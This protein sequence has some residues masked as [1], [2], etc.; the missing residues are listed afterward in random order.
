M[1]NKIVA[2]DGTV[3]L[4]YPCLSVIAAQTL[5]YTFC[6][7]KKDN[8]YID[9]AWSLTF[10]LPNAMILGSM[11]A[12]KQPIDA[13]TI[14]LN[15]CL[16]IWSLRLA[17]HIG[18]RH[19]GEDYR[20]VSLRERMSK[21]GT[22]GYYILSFFLIFML[23]AGL[24][25]AVNYTTMFVTATSSLQTFA[26]G[27]AGT[28]A[29]V[30]SDYLG[31]GIFAAGFLFEAVGDAQLQSHIA[32]TDP[33][34]GKFCKTGLWRYTRHPNYFGE[35][36]LWWGLWTVSLGVTRGW[37]TIFSPI[38]ITFLLR[39]VSGVPLLERKARKHEEWA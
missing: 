18:K 1:G 2:A 13:R 9:V 39:Y 25:L 8:S 34:K 14:A 29:L 11:I 4:L 33:N 36:L 19:S 38:L 10:L 26:A 22:L 16:A 30:W 3:S 6:Q 5:C 15:S 28:A 31:L 35:A 32:N 12:M 37:T 20:Y 24:S 17:W 27:N 21:C 7:I 23:Q